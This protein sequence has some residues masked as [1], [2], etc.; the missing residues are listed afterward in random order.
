M[1]TII[2][3]F[4]GIVLELA[5]RFFHRRIF[6]RFGLCALISA[7]LNETF[8]GRKKKS[9]TF[10]FENKQTNYAGLGE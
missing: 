4:M 9:F 3:Q 10:V 6:M 7:Y 5:M 1:V 8:K 2:K